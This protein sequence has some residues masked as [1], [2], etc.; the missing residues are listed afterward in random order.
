[1]T[2]IGNIIIPRDLA[3]TAFASGQDFGWFGGVDNDGE[4][5]F[6]A[7][8]FQPAGGEFFFTEA[9]DW[10]DHHRFF[11]MKAFKAEL[12]PWMV[13]RPGFRDRLHRRSFNTV[14]EVAEMA[15]HGV[16]VWEFI[17]RTPCL[18]CIEADSARPLVSGV[19]VWPLD[20]DR[21]L[22]LPLDV[23]VI[24]PATETPRLNLSM[25]ERM[26]HKSAVVVGLGSG[27]GVAALALA[28][29][30]I[31]TLTLFDKDRLRSENLFRHVCSVVDLG[32]TK[33]KAVAA[34]IA[35]HALNVEV[36][37]HDD[38][39]F[40]STDLLRAA[41]ASADVVLCAT[42]SPSSRRLVNYLC[43]K[44]NIPLVMG[45]TYDAA[46]IGEIIQVLPYQTACYE[47]TRLYLAERGGL[48]SDDE[49]DNAAPYSAQNDDGNSMP[50]IGGRGDVHL[51]A[52]LQAKTA[53]MTLLASDGYPSQVLPRSYFTWGNAGDVRHPAPFSFSYPFATNF[54]TMP[55]R[56]DCPVCG[57]PPVEMQGVDIEEIYRG[58]TGS[59]SNLPSE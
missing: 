54:V 11:R 28:A 59:A 6:I 24:A 53:L 50:E 31:G 2:R 33:V 16:P 47:C 46:L 43:V 58:I 38:D 51:V 36:S 48:V 23:D 22:I 35:D 34:M 55:R 44:A 56:M 7:L 40:L 17:E 21:H 26:K 15:A 13:V 1:M 10:L 49:T 37:A 9:F 42:D 30:G 18:C 57:N 19:Y 32:R 8:T 5:V 27:G 39:I 12:I 4:R 29:S 20:S 25:Q 3:S 14:S 41:I 45:A 52:L